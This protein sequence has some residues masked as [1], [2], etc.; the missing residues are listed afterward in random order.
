MD[1]YIKLRFPCKNACI[2]CRASTWQ[3]LHTSQFPSF[4][5][6][7]M[8]GP[9]LVMGCSQHLLSW[10]TTALDPKPSLCFQSYFPL[11]CHFLQ[12]PICLPSSWST[13]FLL[14][15]QLVL[16][17]N[18]SLSLSF[19]LSQ[20]GKWHLTLYLTMFGWVYNKLMEAH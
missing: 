16:L 17:R 19:F 6:T 9:L 8:S 13:F 10:W 7:E 12:I 3:A 5:Y 4:L 2:K 14:F 20:F 18:H 15:C 1:Y 11:L